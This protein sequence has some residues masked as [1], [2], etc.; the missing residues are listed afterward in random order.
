MNKIIFIGIS[1]KC[2][3]RLY[4]ILHR[5]LIFIADKLYNQKKSRSHPDEMI[6]TGIQEVKLEVI[7]WGK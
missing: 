3:E 2:S 7:K 4:V 1:L 5:I 6:N